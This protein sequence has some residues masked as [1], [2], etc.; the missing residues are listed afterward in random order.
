MLLS[1]TN[2][3]L[4][5]IMYNESYILQNEVISGNGIDLRV[6]DYGFHN[7]DCNSVYTL[8]YSATIYSSSDIMIFEQFQDMN[9]YVNILVDINC[10]TTLSIYRDDELIYSEYLLKS[11]YFLRKETGNIEIEIYSSDYWNMKCDNMIYVWTYEDGSDINIV[12]YEK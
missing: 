4:A 8:P 5:L 9:Y 1:L 11:K 12:K 2:T 7:I 6:L 3:I 10:P